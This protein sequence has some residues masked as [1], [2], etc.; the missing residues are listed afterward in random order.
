MG[1]A[2]RAARQASGITQQAAAM[3]ADMD[4]AYVS[5]VE[6]GKRS[7]S[8]DRLLRISRTS[9]HFREDLKRLPSE[10]RRQARPSMKMFEP[11]TRWA[12][13]AGTMFSMTVPL[14]ERR[15]TVEE[16]F[17]IEEGSDEKHE[18]WNGVLV[19]LREPLAMAGGS[20]EHGVI[21]VNVLCA[22]SNCLA[23]GTCT[24]L[25]SDVR[26]KL[27]QSTRYVYPDA[28]V[29]CGPPQF[30]PKDKARGTIVN[31]R[32]VIEVLSPSTQLMDRS[33]KLQNY[34]QI[35]SVE[36]YLIV[37]QSQPRVEG[38]FRQ[39]GGTWL[40]TPVE[41]L[42]STLAV[43]CLGLSIP[44]REIFLN[45]QFPAEILAIPDE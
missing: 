41:G 29:V 27:A 25:G 16:Y 5:E 1:R 42:E 4:R 44:F 33:E 36:E 37:S 12:L 15:Y 38:F 39:P 28:S 40:F 2:L 21:S 7:L 8:V 31:P 23:G 11:S 9:S 10:V 20:F 3:R 32:L 22:L 45:I 26:V 30:D 18:Y 13:Y 17:E 43:R 24:V 35:E 6:N 34:L 14:K 19:P